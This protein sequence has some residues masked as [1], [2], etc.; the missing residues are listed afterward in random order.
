MG[1]KK[2]VQE[3][4]PWAPAQPYILSSLKAV[5]DT[6][7]QN[8]PELQRAATDFYDA[9]GRSA[10]GAETGIGLAQ[11]RVNDTLAGRNAGINP[12]QGAFISAMNNPRAT[13]DYRGAVRPSLDYFRKT[14][15]GGFMGGNPYLDSSIGYAI[16]DANNSANS[17][18]SQAGRYGS[19]AHQ[20]VLAREAGR[21]SSN[22]RMGAYEAERGRMGEAAGAYGSMS[23]NALGA[24][25]QARAA[26]QQTQLAAAEAADNGF[27]AD[28]QR[29]DQAVG[30]GQDLRAGNLGLLGN[31]AQLPWM[32]VQAQAGG[33]TGLSSPYGTRTTTESGGFGQALAGMAGTLGGAA[34]KAGV[35]GSDKRLKNDAGVV[36]K[37]PNTGLPLHAYTYKDDPAQTPQVGVMAQDVKKVAP[38]A[39]GKDTSGFMNV[40]Y[41]KLGLPDPT[42][43]AAQL[44]LQNIPKIRTP[45]GQTMHDAFAK[46]SAGNIGDTVSRIG[47]SLLAG[48]GGGWSD[49]GKGLMGARADR[50]AQANQDRTF[51][52]QERGVAATEALREAQ[53]GRLGVTDSRP[54]AIREAEWLLTATPAQRKAYFAAKGPIVTQGPMGTVATPRD[55]LFGGFG[56]ADG[57]DEDGGVSDLLKIY[58]G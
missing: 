4:T 46:D 17:A 58:G 2:T 29:M 48:A 20:G 15:D 30:M 55:S 53:L 10:P 34:I 23:L 21:I 7:K 40:D 31:A 13:N 51:D 38:E 42:T 8:Q 28:Q 37:D 54:S 43:L 24:D 41:G 16:D 26:A 1:K 18:F 19:G 47:E 14:M 45:F 22:A 36:G 44:P 49:I 39:V 33:V 27:N 32:G 35:F 57:T 25:E 6:F 11:N 12:G 50:M 52:I 9:Y 3:N 56:S 5:D